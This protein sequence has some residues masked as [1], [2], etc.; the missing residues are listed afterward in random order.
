MRR[1]LGLCSS[2]C[3]VQYFENLLNYWTLDI[4]DFQRT[5]HVSQLIYTH[6]EKLTQ[7]LCQK[8]MVGSWVKLYTAMVE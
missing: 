4:L 2:I 6:L 8:G 1:N 5:I 7:K 3:I